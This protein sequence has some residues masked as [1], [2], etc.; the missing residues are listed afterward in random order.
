MHNE[1]MHMNRAPFLSHLLYTQHPT[2]GHVA[3]EDEE[4]K[5]VGR[6]RAIE[7][8]GRWRRKGGVVTVF[9]VDKGWSRGMEAALEEC[10]KEHLPYIIRKLHQEEEE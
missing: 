10:K 1:M 4:H 9:Y 3:D 5:A 2:A 7:M 8:A 6:D